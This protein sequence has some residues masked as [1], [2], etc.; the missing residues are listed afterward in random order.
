MRLYMYNAAG[1]DIDEEK[2]P[3]VFTLAGAGESLLVT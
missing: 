3:S 1:S 2:P